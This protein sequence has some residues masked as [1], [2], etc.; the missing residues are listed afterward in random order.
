MKPWIF[1]DQTAAPDGTVLILKSRDREFLLLADNKPLMSSDEHG[2]ED[3]LA[4]LGCRRITSAAA[5]HVLVGGLGMGFTLRAA[6]DVLP[7]TATVV[8]AELVP[9]VVRW[10]RGPLGPLAGHPLGDARVL[11]EETD[12]AIALRSKPGTFDAILLDV[13]NGSDALTTSTNGWLYSDSGVAAIRLGAGP[14][15]RPRDVAGVRTTGDSRGVCGSTALRLTSSTSAAGR[16]A[17]HATPSCSPTSPSA[18]SPSETAPTC[19]R[20]C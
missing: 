1:V 4:T 15:R 11:V 18:G 10:N 16:S 20:R 8:V 7:P 19:V 3:A 5:P 17:A 6:L 12:V 14:T 9:A 13:D 2:S